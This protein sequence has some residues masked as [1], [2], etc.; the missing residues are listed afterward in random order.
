MVLHLIAHFAA[1]DLAVVSCVLVVTTFQWTER[2]PFPHSLFEKGQE[3]C[4]R[5]DSRRLVP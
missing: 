4:W 1:V 2:Q 5:I 3:Q